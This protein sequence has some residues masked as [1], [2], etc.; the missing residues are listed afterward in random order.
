[1]RYLLFIL[2]LSG[3]ALAEKTFNIDMIDEV[4]SLYHDE[5]T[6]EIEVTFWGNS[7]IY[8]MSESHPVVQCLEEAYKSRTQVALEF[9]S[10][11]RLITG[12]KPMTAVVK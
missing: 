9:E 4:R 5:Y 11:Q 12:C 2:L 7:K 10:D 6:G 8:R 1:M 3:S